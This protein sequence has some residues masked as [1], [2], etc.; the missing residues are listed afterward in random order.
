MK[1]VVIVQKALA[2][3]RVTVPRK[4]VNSLPYPPSDYCCRSLI[5][6]VDTKD[7]YL[8]GCVQEHA[9]R[10]IQAPLLSI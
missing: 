7:R 6:A 3:C 8:D 2:M 5:Y 10:L 4:I 1:T 9:T